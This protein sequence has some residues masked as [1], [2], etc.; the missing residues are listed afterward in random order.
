MEYL[1][2]FLKSTSIGGSH[3]DHHV[4]WIPIKVFN[5]LPIKLWK[6]NRP[7]DKERVLEIHEHM[8]VSG[9]MDGIIYL[10]FINDELVC[11]ESNHRREALKGLT[12]LADVL[13]DIIWDTTDDIIKSEFMRLN[14]AVSV[15]ELYVQ[16]NSEINFDNIRKA[17]DDF[18]L[19]YKSHKSTSSN[20]Q[21]PN[22]NRDKLTDE[23][24]RIIKERGISLDILVQKL[25]DYNKHLSL[26]DHSKLPAK[27]VEKCSA[28][29]LW[30]FSKSSKLN[31]SEFL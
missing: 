25:T 28:S 2:T 20:P 23:F 5:Q 11:Y 7:P 17:I 13:V 9:R 6:F 4:Y 26:L 8:K 16:V 29:G 15:P 27:I 30:L 14:K 12:I 10:A 19:T 1:Q 24:Y 18:C 31:D 22:F 21:R 3:G